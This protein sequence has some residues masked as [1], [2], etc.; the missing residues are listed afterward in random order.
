[1]KNRKLLLPELS[2]VIRQRSS[3]GWSQ[4]FLG[5]TFPYGPVNTMAEV[6]SDPQV[7]HSQLA[8]YIQHPSVGR[9]G[10]VGPAVTFSAS[11]NQV[12]GPPPTLGQ[13][14]DLVLKVRLECS[15]S[16]HHQ[17]DSLC[18]VWGIQNKRFRSSEWTKLFPDLV[19][20]KLP[21]NYCD[22]MPCTAVLLCGGYGN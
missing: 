4:T 10:V 6:F 18:R 8:Q 7:E 9:L 14:T 16:H 5:A 12:R 17:Y 3:A 2:E 1:M 22:I 15:H 20:S 13:H 19:R 21:V 11:Q